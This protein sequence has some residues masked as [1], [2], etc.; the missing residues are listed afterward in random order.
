MHKSVVYLLIAVDGNNWLLLF[1]EMATFMYKCT[2]GT[3]VYTE[4]NTRGSHRQ[5]VEKGSD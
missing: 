2:K 3:I 4:N 5:T 1:K